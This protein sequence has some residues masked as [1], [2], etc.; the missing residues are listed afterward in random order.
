MEDVPAQSEEPRQQSVHNWWDDEFQQSSRAVVETATV[1]TTVL[2]D[3]D[4]VL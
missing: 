2:H 3:C 4:T 1:I